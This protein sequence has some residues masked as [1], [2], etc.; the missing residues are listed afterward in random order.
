MRRPRTTQKAMTMSESVSKMCSRFI[1]S[2]PS[3]VCCLLWHPQSGLH[4]CVYA[5]LTQSAPGSP[6]SQAWLILHS[7]HK[8]KGRLTGHFCHVWLSFPNTVS[9]PA[10]K[11]QL[12]QRMNLIRLT[13]SAAGQLRNR[14]ACRLGRHFVQSVSM[15]SILRSSWLTAGSLRKRYPDSMNV[16]RQC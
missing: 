10:G 6:I 1:E 9:R 11:R 16:C 14:A 5:T 12:W 8:R 2:A 4:A 3:C 7:P 13:C 15:S